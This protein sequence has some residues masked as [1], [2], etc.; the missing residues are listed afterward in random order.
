MSQKGSEKME[1]LRTKYNEI[2]SRLRLIVVNEI[3]LRNMMFRW[4]NGLLALVALFMTVI[5][6]F[7][8]EYVLMTVT[9]VFSLMC[10]LNIILCL[11]A[12]SIKTWL[13]VLFEVE[14]LALIAFFFISGIPNGFSAQWICLIPPFALL[15]FGTKKGT[16]F[17][18]IAF[19]MEIFLF[20]TPLG[21]S[22]LM[23]EY[24]NEF[25][26]RFPFVYVAFYIITLFIE[27]SRSETRKQLASLEKKYE[28]LYRHDELTGILNRYGFYEALN[29]Q[30]LNAN[31]NDSALM[32]I[33]IDNF[34]S[35]N[36]KYGHV[37][38]DAVLS[39]VASVLSSSSGADSIIA[40][41]GGEEFIVFV[42]NE[43]NYCEYADG[44]RRAVENADI[45]ID[46]GMIRVTI[47]IGVCSVG[48]KVNQDEFS[49]IISIADNNLYKAK[50]NG[51]NR[52]E[53]TA[54]DVLV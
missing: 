13:M 24:T 40:R 10:V 37:A 11:R 8:A 54:Q 2:F 52:I 23:Y 30:L 7:T 38:G 15:I 44:L 4:L 12:G 9:F 17:S 26:L 16:I 46:G 51:K 5:N 42:C 50:K 21:R 27:T 29:D 45:P 18:V 19:A 35:V 43:A 36:D 28:Y 48:K 34:K 49:R 20:W 47:S 25:M 1:W 6:I 53:S 31:P 3:T 14:A 32:I 33:D 39:K 22:V 41:W